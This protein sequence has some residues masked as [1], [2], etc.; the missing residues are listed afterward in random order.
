MCGPYQ[1]HAGFL[2]L[3]QARAFGEDIYGKDEDMGEIRPVTE[4]DFGQV[5]EVLEPVFRAGDTYTIDSDITRED[6]LAYWL[7]PERRVFVYVEGGVILGTYYV[8]PN[9]AGGGAHVCNCGY[10]TS[11]AARGRGIARM[12]LEHSLPM[13]R[14]LGYLAMQFNFVVSE[15]TRAI[16]IWQSYGFETVGRLPKAFKHPQKGLVDALVM[17]KFL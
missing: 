8:R 13:A 14:S 10:V 12:M 11:I 3:C 15:N 5:W 1:A 9:Q 16:A 7:G 17:Y 4:Q 2:R 6:A